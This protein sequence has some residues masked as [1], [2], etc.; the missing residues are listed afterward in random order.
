MRIV[1]FAVIASVASHLP[2]ANASGGAGNPWADKVVS[3]VPGST[4]NPSYADANVAL[5]GP[6]RFTGESQYPSVVSMFGPPYETNEIVSIG[7]GGSL[8][9][10]FDEPI[11]N[12]PSHLFGVDVIV[13]GYGGFIDA[14]YPTGQIGVSAAL[15][16]TGVIQISVSEDGNNF[17]L[18]P[19]AFNAGF[20]PTQ[21]YLDSGPYDSAPGHVLSD[22]TRPVNP[23]LTRAQFAGLTYQ[24]ALALYGGSGGGTPI[25]IAA[26]GLG[27]VRYVR[28]EV[29]DDGNPF[30]TGN[31]EI[32]AL[33][34]VPEPSSSLLFGGAAFACAFRRKK[35]AVQSGRPARVVG[36]PSGRIAG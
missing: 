35:Q 14:N 18:L 28:I 29:R 33:S 26:S 11:T 32:D 6:E 19:G 15:F 36:A 17:V 16:G 8:T 5:G 25:D 21:G 34:T 31:A 24:Q 12:D 2:F 1:R 22:F 23:A 3:Y 10:E 30:T 27:A 7:E 4:A 20:F 13:F 9:I